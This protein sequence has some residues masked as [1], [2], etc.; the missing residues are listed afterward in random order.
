MK[1]KKEMVCLNCHFQKSK[2]I[3]ALIVKDT[4][5]LLSRKKKKRTENDR[6]YSFLI[7]E[8]RQ[9]NTYCSCL[10]FGEDLVQPWG[11]AEARP[12]VIASSKGEEKLKNSKAVK[13]TAARTQREQRKALTLF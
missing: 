1:C 13:R 9:K 2:V 12:E 8:N 6:I 7:P 11:T 5:L 10:C 4:K 3:I